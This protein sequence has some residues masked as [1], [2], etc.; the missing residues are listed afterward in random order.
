MRVERRGYARLSSSMKSV[1]ASVLL[2]ALFIGASVA[3]VTWTVEAAV[4]RQERSARSDAVR[5]T[6]QVTR[7][8]ISA[9]QQTAANEASRLANR[10]DVQSAFV[11]RA[12][13]ALVAIAR[14]QPEVG[15]VLWDGRRLG[16]ASRSDP[17]TSVRVYARGHF[18][19]RVSVIAAPDDGLL[20]AGR[21]AYPHTRLF[22]SVGGWVSASSPFA[23]GASAAQLL[24][25][26]VNDVLVVG[27]GRAAPRV[28][29]S[30]PQPRIPVRRFWPFLL[31]LFAVALSI[32]VL[33]QR[34]QRR[35]TDA[36]PNHV[37]DAVALVGE[38]FAREGR[39]G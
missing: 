10:L 5:N 13:A 20:S 23:R 15:F 30:L 24:R 37:R 28:Y 33:P 25:H 27:R 17:V 6:L 39:D 8:L 29:A 34:L 21:K 3:A 2:A 19:G 1:G 32:R 16:A 7:D 12:P 22:Y 14:A 9:R 38:A 36:P 31:G 18:Q 26:T 35:R 11:R 4:L